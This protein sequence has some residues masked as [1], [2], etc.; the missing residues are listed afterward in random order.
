[1]KNVKIM[2]A[3]A[4][5]IAVCC[6]MVT[7]CDKYDDSE[8][9]DTIKEL[10]EKVDALEK[11]VAENVSAI[12]SIV[13]LESI[14][15]CSFDAKAGKVTLTLLDGKTI[16]ID[17]NVEGTPLV[18][19]VQDTNGDYYWALCKNGGAEFLLIDGA[20][21]PVSI[22]PSLKISESDEWLISVD[23]GKT[24]H[25]TGIY[26]QAG[27][28]SSAAFFTD[29]RMD[30][31]N[32]LLT[33]AD[34]TVIKVAVVG[35]SSIS[36]SPDSLWFPRA[37]MIK[38]AQIEMNNVK[39]YTITEKP[40]GWKAH[41]EDSYLTV[42]SPEDFSIAAKEGNVKVLALFE[43]GAQPE[44]LSVAVSYEHPLSLSLDNES[45]AVSLSKHTGDDFSGYILAAWPVADYTVDLALQWLNSEGVQREPFTGNAKYAVA[46]LAENYSTKES[47]VVFAAP[48][49]PAAQVAQ[50]NM[51]YKDSDIQSIEFKNEGMYWSFSDISYDY[52][53][54]KASFTEVTSYYGGFFELSAW[55]NY[56]RD[57]ILESLSYDGLTLSNNLS[58]DGPASGFPFNE[59]SQDLLPSTEYVVWML[60]FKSKGKYTENDF[61]TRTFATTGLSKD[62]SVSA[63]AAS[64][65]EVT[66]SGFTATITPASGAYKT[67]AAIRPSSAIPDDE[68][69][70]VTDLMR[71]GNCSKG[72]DP[73]IVSTGRYDAG[74]DLYLVAVSVTKDGG[75]GEVFKQNVQLK[76]LV[77]SDDLA[78]S[79][80]GIQYG[81]G[82]VTL[83]LSFS[84][85]PVYITYFADTFTFFSDEDLQTMMA[86]GQFGNA[87]KVEISSLVDAKLNISGLSVGSLYTFYAVVSDGDSVSSKLYKY[88]FTPRVEVDYVLNSSDDY[89]YG[90]PSLSGT[91][92]GSTNY[93]LNV[94]MPSECKKFWLFKGDPDY[95]TGDPWTDS[96]K[97]VTNA[98]SGVSVHTESVKDRRYSYLNKYSRFY[99]VWLDDKGNYHAI[100]EYNPQNDK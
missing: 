34:G 94:D 17:L 100:Y 13:T 84:G 14:K 85:E 20:K 92:T 4:M 73:L 43:G 96:D 47:Y 75:Y 44:I 93:T 79:V 90:M 50:G 97:L 40:E 35:D 19:V 87:E 98:L 70:S 27:N 36:V 18:T 21:V 38:T 72:N 81:L 12:Q 42:T 95:F 28:G 74:D 10:Q 48:Y 45:V 59:E 41:I 88:D 77:F 33:L 24:W 31:N 62:S 2:I 15:S 76:E 53:H 30:G 69:E 57:N 8:I 25:S 16:T 66:V 60:P 49:L 51:A 22:T 9:W 32:L 80:T 37:A 55:N 64:V 26:Q 54:L 82:D 67:Y 91:W 86:L 7:S 11:Q 6:C 61:V 65:D 5:I 56:G 83:D 39:S 58:Y 99:V 68:L 52:A 89:A 23:G 29:V 1:M 71:L 78:V 46:D 3:N 63:P